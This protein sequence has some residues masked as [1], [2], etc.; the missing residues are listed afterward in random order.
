ML[1]KKS[2]TLGGAEPE[3]Q[4]PSNKLEP[5]EPPNNFSNGSRG[6]D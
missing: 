2:S 4:N 1:T 3:H 6:D 5:K